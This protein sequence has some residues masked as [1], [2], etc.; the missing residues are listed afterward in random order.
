MFLP[1]PQFARS[2]V[3]RVFN[4]AQV[5]LFLGS[6][7]I[8]VGLLAGFFSVLRRRL[9]PLLLWFALF[10]ILYGLRL[11]MNYQL[12]WALGLRPVIFRRVVIAIGYLVPIP[13]FFFFRALNLIGRVGRFLCVTICPFCFVWLWS[14]SI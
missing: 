6:A 12:L 5:F 8:T 11:E 3:L 13:A 2:D 4:H 1:D 14:H 10:A 7:I 9:D